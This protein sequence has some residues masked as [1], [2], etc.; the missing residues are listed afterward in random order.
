MDAVITLIKREI[1]GRD[2]H[3]NEVVEQ[4]ERDVFCQ[5][6][7][8]TRSEFYSAATAGLHPDL[9]VRLS[10]F[11]DYEGE[12]LARY[13]GVLYSIIRVYRDRGSEHHGRASEWSGMDPNSIELTLQKKIGTER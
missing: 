2:A 5:V 1:T 6:F 9:T 7:G 8:I 13:E 11:A 12:E 3:G 10:D 4:T